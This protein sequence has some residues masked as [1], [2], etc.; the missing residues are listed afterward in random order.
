LDK[1]IANEHDG[2]SAEDVLEMLSE[3][4]RRI[5]EEYAL[6][7]LESEE[8][9][10]PEFEAREGD[11]ETLDAEFDQA[12]LV[13]RKDRLANWTLLLAGLQ[14]ALANTDQDRSV[15]LQEFRASLI[16]LA[17]QQPD[18][19]V[20]DV[21]AK[22][23]ILPTDDLWARA[24]VIAA[25]NLFPDE[26]EKTLEEGASLLGLT[27]QQTRKIISNFESGREP[28]ADVSNLVELAKLRYSDGAFPD[29][30]ALLYQE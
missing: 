8:K 3:L 6:V 20:F 13:L 12:A 10:R 9:L 23:K 18:I 11:E 29:L 4:V 7:S 26:R 15:A 2:A 25:Y 1:W 19:T 14:T 24:R 22:S 17:R 27:P 30:S 21:K 5:D 16:D 28:R